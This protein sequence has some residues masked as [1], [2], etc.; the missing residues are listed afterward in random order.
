M[1]RTFC[2]IFPYFFKKVD[3]SK[4]GQDSADSNWSTSCLQL[5]IYYFG[6]RSIMSPFCTLLSVL[7]SWALA[8]FSATI[9]IVLRS[10]KSYRLSHLLKILRHNSIFKP[11]GKI[12]TNF[13]MAQKPQ[14]IV[15]LS[16]FSALNNA[17]S[18]ALQFSFS[19]LSCFDPTFSHTLLIPSPPHTASPLYLPLHYRTDGTV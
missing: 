11:G 13:S 12:F 4:Y 5:H 8:T 15:A 7:Q 3:V 1:V 6:P 10:Q 19:F 17:A 2:L 14:Y 9:N 16:L 18:P